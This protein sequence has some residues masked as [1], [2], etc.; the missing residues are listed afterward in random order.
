[1]NED[2][3]SPMDLIPCI[4]CKSQDHTGS[5]HEERYGSPEP[6]PVGVKGSV[7]VEGPVRTNEEAADYGAYSTYAVTSGDAPI[8]LL[9]HD[10]MRARAV[11]SV[12][13][14][15]DSV[16]VG[17]R[18]QIFATS[19]ARGILVSSGQPATI[20]NKQE[21]WMVPNG[22]D[23]NVSVLNERWES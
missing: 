7:G 20:R 16:W 18:E 5:E 2:I 23:C 1:M 8:R 6:T 17:K 15:T 11:I 9:N 22:T 14:T 13:G 4:H 10:G 21:V 12:D 3:L 19:N